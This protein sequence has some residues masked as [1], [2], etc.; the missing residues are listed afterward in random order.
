MLLDHS[1]QDAG[2]YDFIKDIYRLEQLVSAESSSIGYA[3][4]LTN[5]ASYWNASAKDAAVDAQFR[6]HEG[7][8]L[9]GSRM[10]SAHASAG[11][12]RNRELPINLAG[13]YP[14]HWHTYAALDVPAHGLFRYLLITVPGQRV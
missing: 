14:L 13:T 3:I 6:L 11:T 10:W 1:A 12:T 9:S 2:R 7:T 8:I 5:D 4:F